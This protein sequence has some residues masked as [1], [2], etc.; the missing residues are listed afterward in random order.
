MFVQKIHMEPGVAMW[1]LLLLA[2]IWLVVLFVIFRGITN[3]TDISAA[4]KALWIFVIFMAPVLGL[5]AY[6]AF[7]KKS[8]KRQNS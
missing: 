3:R 1:I 6:L 5:I 4:A 7:G 2:A 8:V